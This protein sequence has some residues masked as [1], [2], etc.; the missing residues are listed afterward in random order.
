MTKFIDEVVGG[1]QIFTDEETSQLQAVTGI[2]HTRDSITLISALLSRIS[3]NP[4]NKEA[5]ALY[6]TI[7]FVE[8]TPAKADAN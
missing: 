1:T 8:R 2:E 5:I 4:N 6:K 3:D 7:M